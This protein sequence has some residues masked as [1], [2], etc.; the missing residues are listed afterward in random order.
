MEGEFKKVAARTSET[1]QER[2][3]MLVR[4]KILK[5]LFMTCSPQGYGY[6]Q[7]ENTGFRLFTEV[8]PCWTGVISGWVT[9]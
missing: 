9:I 6:H 8:K 3:L 2:T 7:R 1:H 4:K 5:I